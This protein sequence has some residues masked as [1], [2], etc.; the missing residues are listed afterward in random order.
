MSADSNFRSRPQTLQ[1]VFRHRAPLFIGQVDPGRLCVMRRT[2]RILLPDEGATL[3]NSGVCR[4]S[5]HE[6]WITCVEGLLRLGKR[7]DDLNKVHVVRV[8]AAGT[9]P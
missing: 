1:F 2:E 6:I 4:I 3:G 8:R 5:D 7:R 9:A